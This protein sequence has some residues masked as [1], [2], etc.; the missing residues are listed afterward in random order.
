[1]REEEKTDRANRG[2]PRARAQ[3]P[4]KQGSV[5]PK[6]LGNIG[7]KEW[8]EGREAQWRRGL[9]GGGGAAESSQDSVQGTWGAGR[10]CLDMLIGT[11]VTHSS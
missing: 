8:G 6:W 3:Q 4:K 7:K 2:G 9:G 11:S 1:M 10:A 5:Q